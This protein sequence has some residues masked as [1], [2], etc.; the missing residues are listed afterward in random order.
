MYINTYCNN[1][2]SKLS[3]RCGECKHNP[4]K[5]KFE[6]DVISTKYENQPTDNFEKD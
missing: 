1:C 2:T 6:R 3:G 4:L 5:D